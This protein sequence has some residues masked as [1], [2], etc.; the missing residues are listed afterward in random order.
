MFCIDDAKSCVRTPQCSSFGGCA[1][2]MP[3]SLDSSYMGQDC[4]GPPRYIRVNELHA[5]L[6]TSRCIQGGTY[7]RCKIHAG[8]MRDTYICRCNPDTCGIHMRYMW[9]RSP[10]SLLPPRSA[11]MRASFLGLFSTAVHTV[12]RAW[13]SPSVGSG[14]VRRNDSRHHKADE[15]ALRTPDA[16]RYIRV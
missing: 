15:P 3:R 5:K 11:A 7:L 13:R 10:F 14:E 2:E 1:T 12:D 8:Y 9:N 4:D 16:V 6:H